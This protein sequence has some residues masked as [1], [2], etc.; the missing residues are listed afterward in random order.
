MAPEMAL[1]GQ[2]ANSQGFL[3]MSGISGSHDDGDGHT[4][5]RVP[6][7]RPATPSRILHLPHVV[8]R[9]ADPWT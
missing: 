2:D 8:H 3:G 7:D 1:V 4:D 9:V 6:I 5:G